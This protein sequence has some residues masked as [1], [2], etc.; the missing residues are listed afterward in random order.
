MVHFEVTGGVDPLLSA[1]LQKG[2]KVLSESNAM[3]SMED[4]LTL[5]GRTRGGFFKSI[6][7]KLLND[8]TF[9]QQYIEAEDDGEVLLAPNIPGDI[10]ILDVGERQYYLSDGAFLASTD[11]V[12]LQVKTQ[13]IGRALLGD[14]GGFFVM[15]TSGHGQIA[16]SGFGSIREVEV[17]PGHKLLVDNGHLVAWDANL[18]YELSLNS[19]RSGLMGK[20]VNSQISGEG[21]LLKFKGEGKVL[22][23][24]RNKGGFLEWIFGQE[25]TDKASKNE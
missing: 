2:D 5:K 11:T 24:S 8:E 22:V 13:G 9:F 21:I 18:D 10:R 7:R 12:S 17:K 23:C 20:I 1:R 19:S 15:A 14:S 3:V 4:T 6:A 16:V 25:K